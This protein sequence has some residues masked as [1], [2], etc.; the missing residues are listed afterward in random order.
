MPRLIAFLRSINV[1]GHNVKMDQLRRIFESLGFAGVETYIASGNVVFE[2]TSRNVK[3]LE[4]RIEGELLKTLGYEV[5]TFVRSARELAHV[6]EYNPFAGIDDAAGLY[7]AFLPEPPGAVAKARLL[8][9]QTKT[10]KFHFHGR[11]LFWS[12]L[13]RFSESTFSGQVL[14]KVLGTQVTVRKSTTVIQLVARYGLR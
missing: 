8:S 3:T 4:T 9:L 10:D 13:T 5:A 12:C 6:A 1:G 2:S 7:I 14:E 11:E